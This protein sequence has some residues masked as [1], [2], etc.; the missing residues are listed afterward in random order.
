MTNS[1]PL[2]VGVL[3]FLAC[4]IPEI[5]CREAAPENVTVCAISKNPAQYDGRA[6]SVYG[7]F[8]S[9]GIE[10]VILSDRSCNKALALQ[11]V[12][13]PKGYDNLTKALQGGLPGTLDK[14]VK[15][16]FT[17]AF[18][19]RPDKTPSFVLSVDEITQVSLDPHERTLLQEFQEEESN[20]DNKLV[21]VCA[22]TN[23]GM[24][25]DGHSILVEGTFPLDA[26]NAILTNPACPRSQ[27]ILQ[28]EPR[29]NRL[30]AARSQL[31]SIAK[32]NKQRSI[33]V[34]LR[35]TF[36][37]AADPKCG[38]PVCARYELEV[39][40]LVNVHETK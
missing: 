16:R 34:T 38:T 37:L 35:G 12:P 36:H 2:T 33:D 1:C 27:L 6:V 3:L 40:E 4:A 25:Y 30:R 5:H 28:E 19:W 32:K 18:Q 13:T 26:H 17:G 39:E 29:S 23:N 22:L 20:A 7:D 11:L 31:E 24:R 14:V 15:A 10:R 8:E 21:N 9:D